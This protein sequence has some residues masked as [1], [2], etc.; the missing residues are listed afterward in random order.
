VAEASTTRET[1]RKILH[2]TDACVFSYQSDF[3]SLWN[4][5]FPK[6]SHPADIVIIWDGVPALLG[7]ANTGI[8]NYLTVYDWAAMMALRAERFRK[9]PAEGSSPDVR[10]HVLEACSRDEF[11]GSFG[12]TTAPL[13]GSLLPWLR[14]YDLKR[15]SMASM[16]RALVETPATSSHPTL[17][18]HANTENGTNSAQLIQTLWTSELTRAGK[19]HSV[20][21]IIGPT[22]MARQLTQL[23]FDPDG[24]LRAST[25]ERPGDL[26]RH[27]WRLLEAARILPTL[28]AK[29]A[30]IRRGALGGIADEPF[31]V[32]DL[33]GRFKQ[34]RFALVDDQADAGFHDVLAALLLGSPRREMAAEDLAGRTRFSASYNGDF[35]LS[36]FDEPEMLL[37]WLVS[38]AGK[39]SKKWHEA[40]VLGKQPSYLATTTNIATDSMPEFD[41]LF[42][43]LRL[44][45]IADVSAE[46]KAAQLWVRRLLDFHSAHEGGLYDKDFGL[47]LDKADSLRQ[48]VEGAKRFGSDPSNVTHVALLPILLSACDPSIPIILF[49]SAQQRSITDLL[50]PFPNIITTFSKPTVTGYTSDDKESAKL[51]VPRLIDGLRTALLLHERRFIWEL[52]TDFNLTS[53]VEPPCVIYVGK[54]VSGGP[55]GDGENPIIQT[56]TGQAFNVR[57][58]PKTGFCRNVWYK[59]RLFE[60]VLSFVTGPDGVANIFSPYEFVDST[61]GYPYRKADV[62]RVNIEFVDPRVNGCSIGLP[63]VQDTKTA[64]NKALHGHL[65]GV[66]IEAHILRYAAAAVITKLLLGIGDQK[67]LERLGLFKLSMSPLLRVAV[68][69]KPHPYAPTTFTIPVVAAWNE[70]WPKRKP[71][72]R[73]IHQIALSAFVSDGR[74]IT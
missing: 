44:H 17:R 67:L 27:F 1:L 74:T 50:R 60:L 16:I 51:L 39:P 58:A 40:R 19:R 14:V 28:E 10:V 48:V 46:T 2:N 35:S 9:R 59:R 21:N 69:D 54:K 65:A 22:A 20:A 52:M 71:A 3:E 43:D 23:G 4:S 53:A 62:D 63:F 37:R 72:L 66:A 42:L 36:S 30:R 24:E 33:L 8:R 57:G 7:G 45:G 18:Q 32:E 11:P 15:E 70:L 38:T 49:S 61:L 26:R 29:P 34:L 31:V 55:P 73:A 68:E 6:S 12:V 47:S 64:R 25:S 5:D 13:I 41:I 56:P